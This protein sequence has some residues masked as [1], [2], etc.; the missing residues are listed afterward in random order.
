MTDEIKLSAPWDVHARKVFE[1]F[2]YDD[3]VTVEYDE[4]APM[5]TIRV[6]N[7]VKAEAL[8]ELLPS[9]VTFG[10]VSLEIEVIPSNDEPTE[11]QIWRQAFDGNPILAEVDVDQLIDGTPVTYALFEPE[12]VQVYADD[13]SSPYGIQTLTYEQLAREVLDAGDV[14]I[15]SDL[16][17]VVVAEEL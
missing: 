17:S 10:N 16:A 7:A 1:L 9:H 8:E 6:A 14:M 15:S 12:V 13:I 3:E 11:D 5:L 2:R 4:A